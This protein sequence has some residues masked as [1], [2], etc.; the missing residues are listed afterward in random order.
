MLASLIRIGSLDEIF[1]VAAQNVGAWSFRKNVPGGL[2]DAV[3]RV[4][5]RISAAK[6][7]ISLRKYG[8]QCEPF[9]SKES[10]RAK[11]LARITAL[12]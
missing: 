11:I 9:S 10:A 12:S 2:F 5:D 1:R 7:L 8:R 3:Y 6:T 4:G